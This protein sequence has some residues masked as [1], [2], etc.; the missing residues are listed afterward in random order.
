MGNLR[1][2]KTIDLLRARPE[3]ILIEV[4]SRCN[5]RCCYCHKADPV[6][7]AVPEANAD[8]TDEMIA[9]LYRYCK[10]E[11]VRNVDH[12]Q[13]VTILSRDTLQQIGGQQ[14]FLHYIADDYSVVRAVRAQPGCTTWLA[15]FMPHL[16][17]GERRWADVW[18]R[19]VRWG[20]TRL[21]LPFEVKAL[22]LF[23]PV[24]GWLA[25]G[26]AGLVALLAADA[27]PAVVFLAVAVHTMAWFAGEAW[28]LAGYGLPFGPRAW[29]AALVREALVPLLAAQAWLGRH[30]IDWRGTDLAAGWRPSRDGAEGKSV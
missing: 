17:V 11:G 18:R 8:M 27:A 23:E 15:N 13:S 24:I 30:R 4:T 7:E 20:S 12:P 25:G 1:V 5:L 19:Q 3:T 9:D 22:V 26:V 16:P 14:G 21:N 2:S 28:F 29:V 6:L 10:A